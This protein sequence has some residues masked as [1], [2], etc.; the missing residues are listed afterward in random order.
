MR[1]TFLLFIF[2][3]MAT[4]CVGSNDVPLPTLAPTLESPRATLTVKPPTAL[5]FA[6]QVAPPTPAQQNTNAPTAVAA[7]PTQKAESKTLA[8]SITSDGFFALGDPNAKATV[9]DYSDFL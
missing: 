6:T 4:A 3:W 9:I 7:A 2:L 1:K 8:Q 5:T